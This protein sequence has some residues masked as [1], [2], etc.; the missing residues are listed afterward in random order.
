M[1]GSWPGK[2]DSGAAMVGM[3]RVVRFRFACT[4]FRRMIGL[5]D[6][7]VCANGEVLVLLPCRSIHTFGM[8]EVIDVA[9][10][11]AQGHV[12]KV[13][14]ALAP[15]RFCACPA[16]VGVL[17]RRGGGDLPW[18]ESGDVVGL[19]LWQKEKD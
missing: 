17:E 7:S 11:D 8:K 6:R 10:I 18:F 19:M 3:D 4:L 5:L 12:V 16:A 14:N 9:F 2:L 15:R 1:S 13:V